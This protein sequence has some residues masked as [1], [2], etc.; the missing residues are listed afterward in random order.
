MEERVMTNAGR[1]IR[2]FPGPAGS[3][4]IYLNSFDEDAE[5]IAGLLDSPETPAHTLAV[6][7]G[8]DWNDEMTPWGCPPIFPSEGAYGGH[9]DRYL[10]WMEMELIP[11]VERSLWGNISYRAI[12]G[13]SLAGLFAIY[14]LWKTECFDCGASMSGSLWYPDFLAFIEKHEPVKRPSCLY[15]SLGDRESRTRQPLMKTVG[16]CTGAMARHSEELGIPTFFEYNP[17][18]H[19]QHPEER[20]AK[21]IR[22]ILKNRK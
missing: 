2:L 18:N 1:T 9:A 10:N 20:I 3:P 15:L 6:V 22:W 21:G 16:T 11:E 17:G 12:A 5:A 14:A 13:Y 19:F 8:I 7:S 4:V